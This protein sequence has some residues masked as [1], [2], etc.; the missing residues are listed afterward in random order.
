[1]CI[2]I[3]NGNCCQIRKEGEK[4]NQI[5]A[6]GFVDDT[7]RGGEVD[8][9]VE[10]EG[11]SDNRAETW[12]EEDNIGCGLSGLTSTLDRNAT[13]GF[14]KRRCIVDSVS[15]HGSQM[16]SLL[17]HLNDCVFVFRVDLCEAV[18]TLNEIMLNTPGQT[19]MDESF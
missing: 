12:R 15:R 2:I 6:D 11:D 17:E 5:H 16:S 9:E 4:D 18:R 10:T 1:M 3:S 7:H 14:L 19:T 8:F 13:V